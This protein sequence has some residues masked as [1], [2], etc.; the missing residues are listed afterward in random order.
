[1]VRESQT[2]LGIEWAPRQLPRL[3]PV[4]AG[5]E[6]GWG[7]EQEKGGS[8]T[9]QIAEGGRGGGGLRAMKRHPAAG[10]WVAMQTRYTLILG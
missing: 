4:R 7:G 10:A 6:S 2:D 3:A 9:N 1:M 5:A 8:R